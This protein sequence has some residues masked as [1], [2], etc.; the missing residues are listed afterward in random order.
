MKRDDRR[1]VENRIPIERSRR[2][3]TVTKRRVIKREELVA[4]RNRR[5]GKDARGT[6]IL[7]QQSTE[8]PQI[9]RLNIAVFLG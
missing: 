7:R 6:T 5:E 4:E 1:R 2:V 9:S 3:L 8:I